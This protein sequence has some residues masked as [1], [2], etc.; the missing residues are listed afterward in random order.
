MAN[1]D[2]VR[3]F[4]PVGHLSGA[5][6]NAG[7]A[8]RCYVSS[9][10]ATAI[11]VGDAVTLIANA[12]SVGVPCVEDSDQGDTNYGIVVDIERWTEGELE[13][14]Y[15]P[16]STGGYIT[17]CIDPGLIML[18]QANGVVEDGDMGANAD[19]VAAGVDTATGTS[20]MEIDISTAANTSTLDFHILGIAD[21]EDNA[22][23]ANAD[24]IVCFNLHQLAGVGVTAVHA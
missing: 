15:L 6:F 4:E 9:S 23:G 13:V 16:A 20:G 3:G 5:P 14:K 21:R 19:L 2:R 10:V 7:S 8:R 12:S 24:L 11:A 22:L 17:V 18:V 1:T